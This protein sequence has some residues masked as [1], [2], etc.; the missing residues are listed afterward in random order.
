MPS[1]VGRSHEGSADLSVFGRRLQTEGHILAE[2]TRVHPTQAGWR[3][4]KIHREEGSS[5][6]LDNSAMDDIHADTLLL[7]S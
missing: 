2:R 7:A 6:S 1:V 3:S 4:A 5:L